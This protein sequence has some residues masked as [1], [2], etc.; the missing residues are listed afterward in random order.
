MGAQDPVSKT[1]DPIFN[2]PELFSIF[3]RFT[4]QIS[5]FCSLYPTFSS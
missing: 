3:C 4:M 1:D 2:F 5:T